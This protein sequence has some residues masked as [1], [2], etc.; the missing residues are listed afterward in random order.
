[1][2]ASSFIKGNSKTLSSGML[3]DLHRG[4]AHLSLLPY[5]TS[6]GVTFS[7][8]DF[9][10]ADEIYTIK[11][12]FSLSY[13]DP[14]VTEIKIDQLDKTI[15]SIPETGE[16]TMAGN[17]PSVAVAVLDAFG[18]KA[19][20]ITTAVKG[21]EGTS[22]K[23]ASFGN[24]IQDVNCTVL[25]ESASLKTAIA[26]ANVKFNVFPPSQDDNSNP[27]YMKFT[28]TVLANTA[29]GNEGDFALLK[30]SV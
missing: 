12:S 21:Q 19:K 24:A 30:K 8:L 27:A 13:S 11:D 26:F 5:P 9:Q 16:Y 10:G 18:K 6:G 23:G 14:S 15:D 1:M 17:I 22:Y 28:A 4:M 3:E 20:D 2:A 25:L 7:T 29:E